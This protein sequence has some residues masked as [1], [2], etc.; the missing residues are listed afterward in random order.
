MVVTHVKK[1]GCFVKKR[2]GILAC[3]L[4]PVGKAVG[5]VYIRSKLCYE[6]NALIESQSHD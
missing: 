4:F 1:R 5:R 2:V 6:I 3:K